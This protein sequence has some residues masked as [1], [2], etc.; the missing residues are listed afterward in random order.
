MIDEDYDLAIQ[1]LLA[2]ERAGDTWLFAYGSLLW[3][4]ACDVAESHRADVHGWHRSFCIRVPRFRGTPEQPGL[5]M[6]LEPGGQCQGMIFRLP[7]HQVHE[8]LDRLFRREL[9]IKPSG[10]RP[11]CHSSTVYP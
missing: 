9:M 11:R 2:Q 7:A 10:N 5:M 4:P 3:K 8:S 6:T 1:E